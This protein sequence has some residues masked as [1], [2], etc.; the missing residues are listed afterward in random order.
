MVRFGVVLDEVAYIFELANKLLQVGG[1]KAAA[2]G[3]GDGEAE[4]C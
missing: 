1:G 3:E 4:N 2:A